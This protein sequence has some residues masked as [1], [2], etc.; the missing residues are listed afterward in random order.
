M[1]YRY[2]F[3]LLLLCGWGLCS[4][5]VPDPGG[6][7]PVVPLLLLLP[8]LRSA[9]SVMPCGGP[10]VLDASCLPLPGTRVRGALPL[11]AEGLAAEGPIIGI[12]PKAAK[13]PVFV[14]FHLYVL[15]LITFFLLQLKLNC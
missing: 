4:A 15:T 5:L 9:W 8:L 11:R 10:V 14:F 6:P 1:S 7:D 12:G 3:F 13:D 2:Y